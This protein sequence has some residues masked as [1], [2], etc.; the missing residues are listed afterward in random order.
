MGRKKKY[1]NE[2][3][4]EMQRKWKLDWYY[5]N[6]ESLNKKRMK[7]YYDNKRIINK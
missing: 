6:R 3:L 2:Q 5:K 7:T 4:K 1:N